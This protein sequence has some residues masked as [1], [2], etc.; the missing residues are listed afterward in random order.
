[1]E[2]KEE[3]SSLVNFVGGLGEICGCPL[4]FDAMEALDGGS[5]GF[6]DRSRMVVY[7]WILILLKESVFSPGYYLSSQ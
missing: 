6:S 3:K 1:M 7:D 4:N 2:E 5:V